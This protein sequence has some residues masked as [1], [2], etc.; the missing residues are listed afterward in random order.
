MSTFQHIMVPIDFGE[1]SEH[2]LDRA[3]TLAKDLGASVTIVHVMQMPPYYY[4]AY[5]E[6]LA[7]PTDELEGA[8]KTSLD[9]ALESAKKRCSGVRVDAVLLAGVPNVQIVEAATD[10]KAD[11]IVMGTHGRR[12]LVRAFLGSVAERVVRT[13]PV[14]VLTV[15]I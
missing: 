11:L 9:A 4:S 14:P 13:S 12:G 10:R 3:L 8:A 6:G 2:A 7:W 1:V 15:S 5:A